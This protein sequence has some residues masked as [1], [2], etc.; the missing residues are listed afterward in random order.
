MQAADSRDAFNKTPADDAAFD[1]SSGAPMNARAR[2]MCIDMWESVAAGED[3]AGVPTLDMR[4]V[5]FKDVEEAT[6]AWS[7]ARNLGMGASCQVFSG[8]LF[9]RLGVAVKKLKVGLGEW[10]QRRFASEMALLCSIAHPNICSLYAFSDDGPCRCLLLELCTGKSLE[11]R[12]LSLPGQ[13]PLEWQHRLRILLGVARAL[14][15]L[16]SRDP[17][18]LHRDVKSANVLLDGSGSTK[19]AD[20]GT[21]REGVGAD[22]GGT[23]VP[24]QGW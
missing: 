15:H 13:A 7:E 12:L 11:D 10:D 9:G 3:S 8:V 24:P 1:P 14:V 4:Q 22:S 6:D 2:R 20:F 16:H 18:M 17:P 5:F 19:V 21:A 23:R